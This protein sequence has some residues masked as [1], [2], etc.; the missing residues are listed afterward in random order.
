MLNRVLQRIRL[1]LGRFLRRERP[2]L[3]TPAEV[4]QPP[5]DPPR[6]APA[7]TLPPVA[8]RSRSVMPFP[9]TDLLRTG[10]V[11][12]HEYVASGSWLEDMDFQ[13]QPE[14]A[15][16]LGH[17][18]RIFLHVNTNPPRSIG[19]ELHGD[20]CL[21]RGEAA[22]FDLSVYDAYMQGVSRRHAL[23]RPQARSLTIADLYSTNGTIVNSAYL[24]PGQP[25]ELLDGDSFSL[26]NLLFYLTII[27]R[28]NATETSR[29][30]SRSGID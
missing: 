19:F 13:V 4:E 11:R 25:F 7:I 24:I 5:A 28:P 20:V 29:H 21:G 3:E 16:R 1:I 26:G 18:W 2:A 10:L 27:Y 6:P 17:Y 8:F 22:D 12:M 15:S 14:G 30:S 9:G 23:L